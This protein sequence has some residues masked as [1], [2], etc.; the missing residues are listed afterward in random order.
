LN[1]RNC[2]MHDQCA[3]V[4][5]Q[6]PTTQSASAL[7]SLQESRAQATRLLDQARQWFGHIAG[8]AEILG[9]QQCQRLPAD[10]SWLVLRPVLRLLLWLV[11]EHA[12]EPSQASA[13]AQPQSDSPGSSTQR[14]G[15]HNRAS[16]SM[17][18]DWRSSLVLGYIRDVATVGDSMQLARLAKGN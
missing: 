17:S 14:H 7:L 4:N 15:K 18:E 6:D 9:S 2:P 11:P 13:A 12:P 8:I 10:M 5:R 16:A 3:P 1:S